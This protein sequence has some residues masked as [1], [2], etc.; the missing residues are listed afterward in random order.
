[1]RYLLALA[2]FFSL[3]TSQAWASQRLAL[4][5]GN[6]QYQHVSALPNPARDAQAMASVLQGLGFQVTTVTDATR[7]ELGRKVLEFGRSTPGA[8]VALVFYAGHGIQ[9][10]GT[11][12]LVPVDAALLDDLALSEEAYQL[13][14]LLNAVGS[15]KTRLIFMDACRDN[16]FSSTMKRTVATR[17][18]GRGLARVGS[19]AGGTM[20]AYATSPDDIAADGD[21]LNSPFTSALLKFLPEAGV[22][23]GQ[24]MRRVR[25]EVA[26]DT[27]NRQIPWVSESLFGTLYLGGEPRAALAPSPASA[28]AVPGYPRSRLETEALVPLS[29]GNVWRYQRVGSDG[30]M[31]SSVLKKAVLGDTTWYFYDELGER[32]WLRNTR[33]EQI[34]AVNFYDTDTISGPAEEEVIFYSPSVAPERYVAALSDVE[35]SVC[36]A[37]I[38][39]PAGRFPCHRYRV[40]FDDGKSYFDS[41]FALGVGLIKTVSSSSEGTEIIVLTE[42][43]VQ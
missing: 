28:A 12:Y 5:I 18:I 9:V 40:L 21:G 11:N 16:P 27:A 22:E 36:E 25:S 33:S 31:E 30:T 24:V 3:G 37:P 42:Y 39:V 4:V 19:K 2:L 23:I 15:A 13:D 34:E 7:R 20:I 32:F 8:E 35:Y 29:V 26:R 10:D 1:M 38:Q 43:S 14:D 17:S 41:Y 6:S